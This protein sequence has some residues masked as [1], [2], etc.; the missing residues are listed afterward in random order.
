MPAS[1]AVTVGILLASCAGD[2]PSA[3]SASYDAGLWPQRP[4]VELSFEVA[5][6]LG[7]VTGLESILFIPDL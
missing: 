2:V 3:G 7:S 4:V 1:I 6:N 5:P